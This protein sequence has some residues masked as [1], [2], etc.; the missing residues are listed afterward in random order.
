[1]D[2]AAFQK[3]RE[4][5]LA[6]AMSQYENARNAYEQ[7]LN[8]AAA[9]QDPTTRATMV[10]Q[11]IEQN[12]KLSTIVSGI[13]T[14]LEAGQQESQ[15]LGQL[16]ST[17]EKLQSQLE[18]YRKHMDEL[19]NARNDASK[20]QNLLQQTKQS[21]SRAEGYYF[22]Y[23]IAIL[24]LL[25]VILVMFMFGGKKA[26]EDLGSALPSQPMFQLPATLNVSSIVP[27]GAPPG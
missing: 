4:T 3:T 15:K 7:L 23:L 20:L 17:E 21:L 9:E 22:G 13:L 18:E 14:A 2:S 25:V 26:A 24:I 19:N 11:L 5:Q 27:S 6:S 10:Q 1:M 8:S 16:G 12:Q